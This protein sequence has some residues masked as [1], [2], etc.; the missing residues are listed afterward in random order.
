LHFNSWRH[1]TGGGDDL[2][3]AFAEVNLTDRLTLLAPGESSI[4]ADDL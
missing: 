4:I 2:S 1:F 3:K